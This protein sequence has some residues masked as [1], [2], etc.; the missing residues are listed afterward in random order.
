VSAGEFERFT[1]LSLSR[2]ESSRLNWFP[3]GNVV[4]RAEC[5]Q[6]ARRD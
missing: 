6:I 1:T 4:L 2:G 3:G 5:H